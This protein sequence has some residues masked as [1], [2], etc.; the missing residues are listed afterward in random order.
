MAEFAG[1]G[2]GEGLEAGVDDLRGDPEAGRGTSVVNRVICGGSHGERNQSSRE[3]DK[4][5]ADGYGLAGFH[6]VR[7]DGLQRCGVGSEHTAWG[8]LE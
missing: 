3:A 2:A 1:G 6:K 8:M 5:V 7:Y 4:A